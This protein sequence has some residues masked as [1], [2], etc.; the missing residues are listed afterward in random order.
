MIRSSSL[1]GVLKAL[2]P[3][4]LVGLLA[5]TGFA[6]LGIWQLERLAWK[7]ALVAAVE[8]RSTG[9]PLDLVAADW[10]TLD[11][12]ESNYQRVSVTGRFL[13]E[14]AFV[15]AVTVL[16]SGFWALSPL[17]LADGRTVLVNRGFVPSAA[18]DTLATRDDTVTLTGLLRPTEPGGGFLR[19]NDL[20]AGRWYSRDVA[21]IADVIGVEAVPAFFIDAN[22]TPDD[23]AQGGLTVLSFSNN[24]LV[25]AL[26]WFALALFVAGALVYLIRDRLRAPSPP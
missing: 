21:A 23:P 7:N 15:Q 4:L 9:V 8:A 11:P 10:S 6:A 18:R 22:E 26:T 3:I 2:W 19:S 5:A 16:G 1:P 14:T 12:E 24:H 20:A 25:Y 17:E 13:P